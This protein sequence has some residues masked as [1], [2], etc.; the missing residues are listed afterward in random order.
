MLEINN[1]WRFSVSIEGRKKKM[2]IH[3][4]ILEWKVHTM[5]MQTIQLNTKYCN[6]VY[7]FIYKLE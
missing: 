1:N 6:R 4:L 7:T 5:Q 3:T 2:E